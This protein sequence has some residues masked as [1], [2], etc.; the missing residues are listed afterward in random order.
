MEYLWYNAPMHKLWVNKLAI[1]YRNVI[2]NNLLYIINDRLVYIEHVTVSTN[3]ICRIIV[4][5]SLRRIIVITFH[6]SSAV[7]HMGE[8]NTLY[9]LKLRFFWPRMRIDIKD[10]IKQYPHCM[11]TYKW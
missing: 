5:L 9:R 1:T 7:S 6:A 8:Y 11:L 2:S 10:W 3:H 4:P